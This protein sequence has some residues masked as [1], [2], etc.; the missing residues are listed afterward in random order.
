[1]FANGDLDPSRVRILWQTPPYPDYVWAIRGSMSEDLEYRLREGFLKI[2]H[3][4]A[5]DLGILRA[6]GAKAFLPALKSDFEAITEIAK[7]LGLL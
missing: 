5:D 1:M 6:I 4:G 7:S 2:G 3:S